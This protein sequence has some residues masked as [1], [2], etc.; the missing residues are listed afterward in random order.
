M[1]VLFPT[2]ASQCVASQTS[3]LNSA[4]WTDG[5]DSFFCPHAQ[6][7]LSSSLDNLVRLGLTPVKVARPEPVQRDHDAQAARLPLEVPRSPSMHTRNSEQPGYG[8]PHFPDGGLRQLS[9]LPMDADP[10]RKCCACLCSR[11]GRHGVSPIV[12]L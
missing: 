6:A 1:R 3:L 4:C 9:V 5:S 10:R 8:R 7:P 2:P 12:D 11:Q